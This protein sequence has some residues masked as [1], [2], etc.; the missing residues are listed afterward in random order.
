[1]EGELDEAQNRLSEA[2]TKLD[3]QDKQLA[4]VYSKTVFFSLAT[5]AK[6]HQET[7]LRFV[8]ISQVGHKWPKI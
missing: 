2:S 1:M 4:K 8:A 6:K 3:S 5:R 7:R